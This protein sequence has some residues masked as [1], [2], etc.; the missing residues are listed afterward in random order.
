MSYIERKTFNANLNEIF[1]KSK[2]L[3]DNWQLISTDKSELIYLEKKEQAFSSTHNDIHSFV[4]NVV[5]SESFEVPVFYLNAYKSNGSQLEFAEIYKHFKLESD[6]LI[7]T[8]Q[9]HPILF[10]PFY[11]LHPCKTAEWMASTIQNASGSTT[12]GSNY[13]LKWLSFVCFA[14]NISFDYLKY[15]QQ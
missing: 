8:Q 2:E 9:E 11:F 6:L 15:I 14:L 13:T 5:Y 4:Y 10:K 1:K 12:A 3:N 7:L